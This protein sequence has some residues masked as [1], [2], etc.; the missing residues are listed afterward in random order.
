[1]LCLNFTQPCNSFDCIKRETILRVCARKMLHAMSVGISV[2]VSQDLT[3]P[4]KVAT[5]AG[6]SA[7]RRV[8]MGLSNTQACC[9]LS[10]QEADAAVCIMQ[11]L[12]LSRSPTSTGRMNVTS[13]TSLNVGRCPANM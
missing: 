2:H 1:M 12:N 9:T 6:Q 4:A 5:C 11:L 13:S 8:S 10:G 7:V 3:V